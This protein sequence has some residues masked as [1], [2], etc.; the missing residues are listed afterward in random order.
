M[1][2]IKMLNEIYIYK[3][4]HATY[5]LAGLYLKTNL[6]KKQFLN[7][8]VLTLGLADDRVLSLLDVHFTFRETDKGDGTSYYLFYKR[9]FCRIVLKF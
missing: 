4:L 5:F 3:N 7:R 8:S 9:I 1:S 6:L 2:L